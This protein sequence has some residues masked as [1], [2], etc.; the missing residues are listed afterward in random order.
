MPRAVHSAKK[1]ISPPISPATAAEVGIPNSSRLFIT[2]QH[3]KTQYLIDTGADVSI[4]PP[5]NNERRNANNP[6]GQRCQL[7]AANGT[8]IQTYGQRNI[9]LSLGL[10]RKFQWPFVIADV[11][12]AIIGADFL[13]YFGLLVDLRKRRL[14]D[15]KTKLSTLAAVV[16]TNDE[17]ISTINEHD[18]FASLVRE[19]IDITRPL[20]ASERKRTNVTHHIVTKGQPVFERPRRLAPD[21]L[22]IAKEEF[23]QLMEAGICR[24]S[25]SNWASPLHLVQKSNGTWRPCGDYRRLNAMTV[26]DRYPVPHIHD[27]AHVFHGKKIFSKIDLA[28]AY[29]QIPI[30][31]D[32]IPK[33]AITTP[34]GLFEFTC[35]TFGLCNAG[36]TFQRFMNEVLRGLD[37]A[38]AYI[39]DV[40]VSSK[41][42]K[43]HEE[44]LR[45]VFERFREYGI[46]INVSKCEFGRREMEFLGHHVNENGITPL[47]SK[48]QAIADFKRPTIAKE[49][50][51][52]IATINFYRRFLP[53]AVENQTK[54]QRLIKGN[55]KNDNTVLEW[56]EDAN[57]AFEKCKCELANA[58]LLSH[59]A[60]NA[61][62]VLHVDASDIAV[63]AALHQ[64]IDG[65]SQPLGFYSKRLTDT[66]KRYSTYDRE[67]LAAYQSV[68][69][70]R[71]M[72]EAREFVL[73]TD[74]MPLT[75][76]FRQKQ[77]KASPRQA[78]HLDYVGQFTTNIQHVSGSENVIADFLSRIEGIS[79]SNTEIDYQRM[80]EQQQD[81]D[82]LR[83]AQSNSSLELKKMNL[84]NTNVTLFCDI[85]TGR[86][87]P[88]V[89][90]ACR[91]NV[92]E[93][94]HR[95][96]HPGV[97]ASTKLISD[98][99]VWPNM[100]KEIKTY[101]QVCIAC[102]KSKI[103]RHN[104]AALANYATPNER[105]EHV[106]IDI[107]GP[108]PPSGNNRYILTMIDRFSRWPEAAPMPDQTAET[109]AKTFIETWVARFG[110]PSK[111]T[112]DRGRQFESTLFE[113]LTATIGCQHFRTTS[114]H[115]QSNGIIERWHRTLKASL[116]CQQTAS[117]ADRL[118]TVLLGLR[119]AHKKDI[120]ASPAEMLYGQT[121]RLPG[122]LFDEVKIAPQPNN[123]S[124]FVNKF[125][126]Q[127]QQ[128]KPTRTAH[129][130]NVNPFVH[131]EL[132][133]STHA[134][135]RNDRVKPPLTL[136]YDGPF[137]IVKRNE[138][139]YKMEMNGKAI[140]ISIDRLK[141]AFATT[142]DDENEKTANQ[143]KNA[144]T[145]TNEN[146]TRSGR[147]V[148]F[149]TKYQ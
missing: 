45:A 38:Y 141:P 146:R 20:P 139:Y 57:E 79:I 9:T 144:T 22:V 35:M 53:N 138:K 42:E 55:K 100:R 123:E 89:P 21:K 102:Q 58:V 63:G 98:R 33:T 117:W 78:R 65:E 114:Y 122:E 105:F 148:R 25:D 7:Y 28:K 96:S 15:N 110:C 51:R 32:D 104:R 87:R 37:F 107:V 27:F 116:M 83:D 142:P 66:Q 135:V 137:K 39:D 61:P 70:F 94:I 41:D 115:P 76:A 49:L 112:T 136:P 71:H 75:F 12:R 124:E 69:H 24:P 77:D 81:D 10:R 149:P 80:A 43:E 31:P 147:I 62:L 74:H 127:M 145:S 59:P 67:L 26:P 93:N 11:T 120:D 56:T 40:S 16:Q 2:D 13:E 99:F 72:L 85:S 113:R 5:T 54:L 6:Y 103:H 91:Q 121:L 3:S 30:E 140:N 68:K 73:L 133:N 97:R 143:R 128:I 64:I 86:V 95:F 14:I 8:P 109:V 1:L 101:V 111:I 84:P 48:V 118:P 108:L 17:R 106:N 4:I 29:N 47:P 90:A 82:E 131:K 126:E 129:H 119:T 23:R 50:R 130:S 52:F 46:T 60:P 92:F 134:F 88:F 125:R 34:F 19:F 44:H 132:K 18:P 36:Q